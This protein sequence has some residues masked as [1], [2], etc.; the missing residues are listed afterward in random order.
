[1]AQS[2]NTAKSAFQVYAENLKRTPA[3]FRDALFRHDKPDTDR[4]RS[5]AVFANFFL[6][7]HSTRIHER[8][9]DS[10][11]HAVSAWPRS[12]ASCC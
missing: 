1:M 5:Q 11:Q 6:H 3:R 12:Q 2:D 8:S 4:A 7:L 10:G 9:C